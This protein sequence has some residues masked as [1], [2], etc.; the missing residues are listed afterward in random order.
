MKSALLLVVFC[1]LS[2]A[3]YIAEKS[4]GYG[5][6]EYSVNPTT[7]G[8]ENGYTFDTRIGE[9]LLPAELRIESYSPE[10]YGYYLVQFKGPIFTRWKN[11]LQSLGVNIYAYFP[12]NAFLVGLRAEQVAIVKSLSFIQWVGIYQPAYKVHCE[13]LDAK[14]RQ[15]VDVQLYPDADVSS[16]LEKIKSTGAMILSYSVSEYGKLVYIEHE[17]SQISDIARIPEVLAIVPWSPDIP[18]N[19][20]SQW[21][22]QKG[23]AAADTSRPIWRRGIRGQNML[24]GFSDTGISVNHNAYRD[25][26]IPIPDSGRFPNH[27]KIIAYLLYPTA[28]F[29]DVGTTYHGSHVGGTIAGDDSIMGG[30]NA[31]DGIAYKGRLFFVDIGN[32]SG[33]LVT[34]ADLTQ[35]YQMIYTAT[36]VGPVRQH[37]ASW[38][39]SGTGYIDRD[40]FSDAYHWKHKDFLDIFA[41]GNNGA[42]R[43][44]IHAAYAKNVVAVGAVQNGTSSNQIAAF[45]SRGGTVDG[46]IKPTVMTP[47]QGII[48]V[49]GAGTSGYKSLDGTSMAT[50]ACNASAGLIRQYLKEGWYPTGTRNAPDSMHYISQALLRSMLIVSADPNVGAFVVPDSNIGFGRVDLDSVLFFLGDARK[51]AIYDDT[52]GLTTGGFREYQIRVVDT[53]RSLR[54]ALAWPD[55]AAAIGSNPNIVNNLDLQITNAFG[56]YYRGNQMT[57]GQS[58]RNPTTWDTRNVEEVARINIP[59]SGVWTIRVTAQSVPYPRASYALAITGGL[60]PLTFIEEGRLPK[61]IYNTSIIGINPNPTSKRSI[62]TFQLSRRSPVSLKVFDLSGRVITTL[63]SEI[64]DAGHYSLEWRVDEKIPS[65]VYFIKFESGNVKQIQRVTIIH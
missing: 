5:I 15:A 40:A 25:P 26:S 2:M 47:G 12:Q 33:G 4:S 37:S 58:I 14:G 51:L 52:T 11:H 3:S 7:I 10:V 24:L 44:I 19:L 65:G 30:T 45:S 63:M 59:R 38:G 54:L 9:P 35:L 60:G 21:V 42:P 8:L 64:K 34:P 27:R 16:V 50:P 1:C 32:A 13:L 49:D 31:N 18:L 36:V 43:T 41:A 17:L 56:D 61:P 28:A 22:C 6:P 46:R 62:I 20:N 55:T 57:G 53:T 39:R 29:G 23:W 48:S